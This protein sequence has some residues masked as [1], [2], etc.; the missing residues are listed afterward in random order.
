MSD[1]KSKWCEDKNTT[2]HQLHISFLVYSWKRAVLDFGSSPESR[3]FALPGV[4]PLVIEDLFMAGHPSTC[5]YIRAFT[6]RKRWGVDPGTPWFF[7]QAETNRSFCSNGTTSTNSRERHKLCENVW[8]HSSRKHGGCHE[9]ADEEPAYNKYSDTDLIKNEPEPMLEYLP[10][11]PPEKTSKSDRKRC[12]TNK[13]LNSYQSEDFLFLRWSYCL[14]SGLWLV[15][16]R[17]AH[18]LIVTLFKALKGSLLSLMFTVWT[19]LAD[20]S[21]GKILWEV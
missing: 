18:R 11:L 21:K 19:S 9:G 15:E 10:K 16:S 6:A 13:N 17:D 20:I 1:S 14:N 3:R 2:Q 5:A 4:V 12:Q 8:K 7:W